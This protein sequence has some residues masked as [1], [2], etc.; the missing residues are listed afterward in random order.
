MLL[1]WLKRRRR[2]RLLREPMPEPWLGHLRGIRLAAGLSPEE[3]QTLQDDL[4]ILVAEKHWEG[5]AGL[6]VTDEIRVTVAA[7]AAL[8]LLGVEHD[9]FRNVSSI[10]VYPDAFRVPDRERMP[11]GLVREGEV[12][13]SGLASLR[14][15]VILSWDDVRRGNE[16]PEDGRNVVLH[17][18]AHKLDMLDSFADGAP[19]LRSRSQYRAWQRIMTE[20]YEALGEGAEKGRRTLLD[21]YGATNP[22]EFFAVATEAFFEKA[23]SMRTKHPGLYELL[24]E[25]YGQDPA[26]RS[27]AG[28]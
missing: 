13:S 16:N 11:G 12:P 20:E 19:P 5:C 22:A 28:A 2:R 14:G 17:E 4:R 6:E 27:P 23:R 10:L 7:Q 25:Y 9:Y 15:P 21:K 26:S 8:L 18:F 3:A 24:A 1:S